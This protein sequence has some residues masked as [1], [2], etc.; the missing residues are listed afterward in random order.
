MVRAHKRAKART[1]RLPTTN[2]PTTRNEQERYQH[3]MEICVVSGGLE[4][5]LIGGGD[6]KDT[7]ERVL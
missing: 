3:K 5:G 7:D 4:V 2:H 1:P 6:R